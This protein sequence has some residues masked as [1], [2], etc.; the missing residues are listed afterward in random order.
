MN[1]C[2]AQGQKKGRSRV[3]KNERHLET[4]KERNSGQPAAWP[5]GHSVSLPF[6]CSLHLL[7]KPASDVHWEV[8]IPSESIA[9]LAKGVHLAYC[10][11]RLLRREGDRNEWGLGWAWGGGAVGGRQ[12]EALAQLPLETKTRRELNFEI[13]TGYAWY[14]AD[15]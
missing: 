12:P 9:S 2:R 13:R 15:R 7:M 3:R 8:G 11:G 14:R 4:G 6:S 10:P 1:G 5:L